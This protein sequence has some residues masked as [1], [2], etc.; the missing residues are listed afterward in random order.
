VHI[1]IYLSEQRFKSLIVGTLGRGLCVLD[2]LSRLQMANNNSGVV[3]TL[4]TT[5]RFGSL[6]FVINDRRTM[7]RTPEPWFPQRATCSTLP[8]ASTAS[9]SVPHEVVTGDDMYYNPLSPRLWEC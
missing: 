8:E 5:I 4:G 3:W 7:A 1:E 2:E 9:D 6:D